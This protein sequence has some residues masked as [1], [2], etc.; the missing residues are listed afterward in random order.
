MINIP[1]QNTNHKDATLGISPHGA[2][3]IDQSHHTR[4]A[5]L[6]DGIDQFLDIMRRAS[7]APYVQAEAEPYVLGGDHLSAS[8]STFC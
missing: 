8:C 5:H 2:L 3:R 1:N 6:Y 4:A 7:L